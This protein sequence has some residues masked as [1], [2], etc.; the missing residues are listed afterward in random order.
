[1]EARKDCM[2]PWRV[3]WESV[4]ANWLPMVVLWLLAAA[5]VAG[6]TYVPGVKAALQPV[7]DFQTG[8]GW[9]AA[10]LNRIVFCGLLPGAFWSLVGLA[11]GKRLA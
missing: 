3:G 5:L 4:K 6:Y 1:M 11:S 8:G 10:V 9:K 2:G 7:F